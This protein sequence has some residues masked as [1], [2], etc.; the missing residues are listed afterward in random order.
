MIELPQLLNF[1]DEESEVQ[2][3]AQGQKNLMTRNITG[4]NENRIHDG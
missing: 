4:L 1:V 2:R 3:L